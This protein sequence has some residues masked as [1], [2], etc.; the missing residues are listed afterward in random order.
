MP[1][2]RAGCRTTNASSSS[3]TPCSASS[4]RRPCTMPTRTCPRASWPSCG[5][6]WSTCGP[7]PRWAAP[8]AW[9]TTSSSGAVRRPPAGATRTRSSPTPSRRSSAPS[10]RAVGSP[11]P[12]SSCT[13]SSTRSSR[14][15][16]LRGAG[17]DW[18]TSCRNLLQARAGHHPT[19]S[20]VESG[21]E[22]AKEFA[23]EVLVAGRLLGQ[24]E[25]RT[26][27]V[28]EQRAAAHAWE[29]PRRAP[30][31]THRCP[32]CPRSRSSGAVWPTT[33]SGRRLSLGRAARPR[34]WPAAMSPAPVDL[35]D[36]L[37]GRA[38]AAAR[39]RGKYLW[40]DLDEALGLAL[41]HLGMSGQLLV[42]A[43]AP[44]TRST[45]T[46]ASASPTRSRAALRR[47]ADLRRAGAGRPRRRTGC[48]PPIAHIAPIPFDDRTD[49]RAPWWAVK[50]R[51]ARS[52]ACCS[53]SVVVSGIGNIYADEALWRARST[54]T[55]GSTA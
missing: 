33:S 38:S 36:R 45:C 11:R 23:A 17:L 50:A 34:A 8:S 31:L 12:P 7:W 10:T 20:V 28:A 48:R 1:T 35:A 13:T 54:A 22:H 30:G 32:N 9:V 41:V 43:A 29:H 52:N 40:L 51:T 3:A 42:E 55:G 14:P 39:R 25:G 53:T 18:K 19:Y 4:S 6:P 47:P 5:P 15:S 27:K 37:T 21:P 26:K 49:D 16:A 2:R 44:R 46:P 24:G